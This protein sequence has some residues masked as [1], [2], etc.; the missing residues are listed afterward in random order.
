MPSNVNQKLKGKVENLGVT[1]G[2]ADE[3]IYGTSMKFGNCAEFHAANQLLNGGAKAKRIRWT[4][5]YY[6]N[7]RTGTYTKRGGVKPYCPNCVGMFNLK[8]VK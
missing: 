7:D 5:A 3:D 8:N 4:L 2:C 6:I 1:L